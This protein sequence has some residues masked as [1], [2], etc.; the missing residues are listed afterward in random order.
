MPSEELSFQS[1]ILSSCFGFIC[2]R[3]VAKHNKILAAI[4]LQCCS[5][6]D[7]INSIR[8]LEACTW[9]ECVYQSNQELSHALYHSHCVSIASVFF[10]VDRVTVDGLQ[11]S[12]LF[13]SIVFRQ[14]TVLLT[15][16]K[17]L[18]NC[19]SFIQMEQVITQSKREHSANT[20]HIEIRCVYFFVM[21]LRIF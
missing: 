2:V 12:N 1:S 10:F 3:C 4:T 20:K 14:M 16:R 11:N 15:Q 19:T 5:K 8:I 21:T 6:T 13:F 17:L 7:I 9:F 18:I